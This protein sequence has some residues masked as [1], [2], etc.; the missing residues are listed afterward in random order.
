MKRAVFKSTSLFQHIGNN[1]PWQD[2][3][4]RLRPRGTRSISSRFHFSPALPRC[5]YS[6]RMLTDRASERDFRA[7]CFHYSSVSRVLMS[8]GERATQERE[9]DL[10]VSHI[11][12]SAE[13]YSVFGPR[14]RNELYGSVSSILRGMT[15]RGGLNAFGEVAT[16]R[17][18]RHPFCKL[19]TPPGPSLSLCLLLYP[20]LRLF[21]SVFLCLSLHSPSPFSPSLERV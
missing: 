3:S 14:A 15:G 13:E 21:S 4:H 12:P 19:S 2:L 11:Q 8:D 16:V 1:A 9:G 10:P 20:S 6:D 5:G 18:T 17:I 7:C